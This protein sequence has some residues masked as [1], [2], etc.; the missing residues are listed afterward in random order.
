[1]V[2]QFDS[3]YQGNVCHKLNLDQYYTPDNLALRCV[4]ITR[5]LIGKGVSEYFETSA[6]TG[7]FLKAIR[8]MDKRT[9]ITAVDIQPKSA[10]ITTADFLT[11]PLSYRKGRCFIGNPPFGAR[12][13]VAHRFWKRCVQY[14]D[15][16]AWILPISQLNSVS[17][18]YEFDLIYSAD[19]GDVVFSGCK[20]VRCCFNVYRRPKNGLNRK[21]LTE[22]SEVSFMRSDS[23]GYR[24]FDYD[25]RMVC[26]GGRAG[27]LLKENEPDLAMVYRIKVNDPSKRAYVRKIIENT[28]WMKE[29]P[30]VSCKKV[31]KTVIV[32]VLK[33]NGIV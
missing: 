4:S 22:L 23:K 31:Q 17:M 8:V 24:D 6:G 9:P 13:S 3:Q 10:G 1:M 20:P 2:I 19:L 21:A 26:W 29:R 33:R 32:S 30:S 11:M 5:S 28:D 12:M 14:G 18:L 7:A 16:V 25:F 15:Y 27:S